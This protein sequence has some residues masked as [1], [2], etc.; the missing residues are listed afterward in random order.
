MPYIA[1]SPAA[2]ASSSNRVTRFTPDL[3]QPCSICLDPLD[4]PA[5]IMPCNHVF[6]LECLKTYFSYVGSNVRAKCCPLCR[7]RAEV[8]EVVGGINDWLSVSDWK[9]VGR[10]G[11]DLETV[12][13]NI[14]RVNRD[15]ND[16]AVD[17]EGYLELFADMSFELASHYHPPAML[18]LRTSYHQGLQ[19]HLSYD[20]RYN[21]GYHQA[22]PLHI[23][24]RR[25]NQRR[26][27]WRI[28][29]SVSQYSLRSTPVTGPC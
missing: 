10:R 26:H 17:P 19:P 28:P 15:G 23:L 12:E 20:V 14:S 8:I 16:V 11:D 6:D 25:S 22:P 1:P 27:P 9:L 3:S 4:N 7:G 24:N 13:R 5:K 18:I 29:H 2:E 21:N